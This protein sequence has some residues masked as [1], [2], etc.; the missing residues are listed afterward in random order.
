VIAA[1]SQAMLN[2]LSEHDI[3]DGLQNLQKRCE[4]GTRMAGDCFENNVGQ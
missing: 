3:Q 2:S 1:E 4:H